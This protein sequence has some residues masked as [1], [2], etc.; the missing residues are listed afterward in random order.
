MHLVKI[1][2]FPGRTQIFI[3]CRGNGCPH[4]HG[5]SASGARNARRLLHKLHGKR[6]RAGDRVLIILKA[7]GYLPERALVKIRDGRLPRVTQLPS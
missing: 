6:Y 2:S 5:I 3:Q 4:K 1:G 7:P